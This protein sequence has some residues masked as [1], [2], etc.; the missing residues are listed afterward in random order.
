MKETVQNRS[1][2]LDLP[3]CGH[4][5]GCEESVFIAIPD[6]EKYGMEISTLNGLLGERGLK[7]YIMPVAGKE[8]KLT[9]CEQVCSKIISSRF[10]IVFTEKN[11]ARSA[12]VHLSYGIMLAFDKIV[13]PLEK[14]ATNS[15]GFTPL[16]VIIYYP[17][18][19]QTIAGTI[20]EEA[21]PKASKRGLLGMLHGD[22]E[23]QQ[24]FVRH[25]LRVLPL[26]NPVT[27]AFYRVAYPLDFLILEGNTFVFFGSFESLNHEEV[28]ARLRL[29]IQGLMELKGRFETLFKNTFS[30]EMME[31]AYRI[32][33][34]I[35]IETVVSGNINVG[36]LL[37]EISGGTIPIKII[38]RETIRIK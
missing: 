23:L 13:I 31:L 18:N 30:F 28:A 37:S 36:K 1:C 25:G 29:L 35:S 9:F 38:N 32:F 6:G 14:I 19:F 16:P 8:D 2:M 3:Y 34:K 17:D 15:D 27:R 20:I 12:D 11:L 33:S 24:Y 26:D 22:E 10:C 7:S 5:L 4:F 21:L